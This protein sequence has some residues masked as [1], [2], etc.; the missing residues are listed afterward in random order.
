MHNACD[1]TDYVTRFTEELG[2]PPLPDHDLHH[3]YPQKFRDWFESKGI[4]IDAPENMFELPRD[5]HTRRPLG[6]HTGRYMDSWNGRWDN[7]IENFPN[8]SR[9]LIT[10]FRDSLAEVYKIERYLGGVR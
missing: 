7:F 2:R 6:V 10:K 4:D 8:A 3:G 1:P 9:T 5:L